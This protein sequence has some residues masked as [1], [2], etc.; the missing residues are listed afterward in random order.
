[1]LLVEN[2]W[3]YDY[4]FDV[5]IINSKIALCLD[6]AADFVMCYETFS[7]T[8]LLKPLTPKPPTFLTNFMWSRVS[9]RQAISSM[10]SSR[11]FTRRGW[12]QNSLSFL[13]WRQ[14]HHEF[15]T[16]LSLTYTW[17]WLMICNKTCT[18]C[19]F[20]QRQVTLIDQL[21]DMIYCTH[22]A[23]LAK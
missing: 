10:K 11:S 19:G 23:T 12:D 13:T 2:D 6:I 7:Y 15:A 22:L 8:T 5:F 20:Y 1:M 21:Q 18:F 17:N 3:V 4:V 14:N 9:L 16:P